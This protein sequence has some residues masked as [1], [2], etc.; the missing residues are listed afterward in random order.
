VRLILERHTKSYTHWDAGSRLQLKTDID[1]LYCSIMARIQEP[2]M[3]RMAPTPRFGLPAANPPSRC[4]ST[5]GAEPKAARGESGAPLQAAASICNALPILEFLLDQD[6]VEA[7]FV[8]G[9]FG[10]AV[11]ASS[12]VGDLDTVQMRLFRAT[13]K[14]H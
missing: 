14:Q 5:K 9:Q 12:H 7:N 2:S 6:G 8:S 3:T 11:R 1:I 10:T 4:L 13:W